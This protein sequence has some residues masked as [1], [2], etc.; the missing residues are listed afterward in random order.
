MSTVSGK[1]ET[2]NLRSWR[3]VWLGLLSVAVYD[4]ELVEEAA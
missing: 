3:S 4:F 1:V 2:K